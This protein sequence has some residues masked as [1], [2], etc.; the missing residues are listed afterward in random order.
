[1][2]GPKKRVRLDEVGGGGGAAATAAAQR[3]PYTGQMYSQ[4]YHDILQKRTQLPVWSYRN[5]FAEMVSQHQIMV[6]VGETGSGKTT[7]VRSC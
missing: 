4:R 2:D 7:Q 1:M 6:L 5:D 3:N